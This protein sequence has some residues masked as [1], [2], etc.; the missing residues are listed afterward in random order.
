MSTATK[1]KKTKVNELRPPAEIRENTKARRAWLADQLAEVNALS[2]FEGKIVGNGSYQVVSVYSVVEIAGRLRHRGH[3]Q[4]CGNAQVVDGGSLVLHGYSRPGIGYIFNECPGVNHAPLEVSEE[5]TKVHL[6]ASE[7]LAARLVSAL[8]KAKTEHAAA[9]SARYGT[10]GVEPD[11]YVARPHSL[12]RHA[13]A[14]QIAAH[15]A[16][17]AEWAVRFPITARLVDAEYAEAELSNASWRAN[18]QVSHFV[19]LLARQLLGKDL[20]EEVVA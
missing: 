8:K 7:R 9:L 18:Q 2:G 15:K 3:C 5:L 19:S 17:L 1:T 11:A 4:F 13:T 14:E 16:A 12:D 10:E 6:K 20:L